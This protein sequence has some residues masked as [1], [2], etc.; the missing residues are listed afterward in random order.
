[1]TE[2]GSID[3]FGDDNMNLELQDDEEDFIII[4][5]GYT[6]VYIDEKEDEKIINLCKDY[7]DYTINPN[8]TTSYTYKVTE[9]ANKYGIKKADVSEIVKENCH[10]EVV[11]YNCIG[12]GISLGMVFNRSELHSLGMNI[13]KIHTRKD[14]CEMCQYSREIEEE[15]KKRQRAEENF[16]ELVEKHNEAIESGVYESLSNIEW[17]YLVSLAN[18]GNNSAA[19]K[20][21]GLSTENMLR[22]Y[23]K[24]RELYIIFQDPRVEGRYYIDD[25]FKHSLQKIGTKTQVKPIFGS[26]LAAKAY[27]KLKKEHLFVY[28]EIPIA[29]FIE[30]AVVEHIFTEN[31][32]TNYFL[33]ARLDF[34][35]TQQDGTP[36]FGVEFQGSYHKDKEQKQKDEFKELVLA[37]VG[38]PIQYITSKDIKENN[39]D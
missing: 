37:E 19:G 13:D 23:N 33:T 24:L 31:W 2:N 28:P 38:L 14:E 21:L 7:W 20:K 3:I 26:N 17:N 39:F 1:M 18:E 22:I 6:K 12:C 30:K 11:G 35:V 9:L 16:K 29:A 4:D 36:R 27:R 34:V 25:D 8:K 15:K 5:Q 32:H 10:L